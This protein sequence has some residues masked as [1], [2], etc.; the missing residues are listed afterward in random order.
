MR[1]GAPLA[2]FGLA[3]L[4]SGC[5][6]S[7]STTAGSSGSSSGSAIPTTTQTV[8]INDPSLNVTPAMSLTI[9]SGWK[10]D[11]AMLGSAC[12]PLPWPVFRAY[13][14]DGLTEMRNQPIF[15][16]TWSASNRPNPAAKAC[17]PLTGP[18]TA[19]EFL[20]YYVGTIPGGVHIVGP[21]PVSAKYQQGAQS[22]ANSMNANNAHLMAPLQANNTADTA[23]LRIETVNG[24]FVI[25][26][27]LRA[28]LECAIRS[29]A[30][31]FQGGACFVRLD[32]LRA[33]QGKLDA[34]ANLVDTNNLPNQ[35]P[36]QQWLSAYM[37]RQQ[38]QGARMLA[39]LAQLEQQESHMLL[40][41]HQQIM[42]TMQANHQA[43]MAQ[44]ESQF[45]SAMANA[46]ASMNAQ[47]TATSDWVDYALDQQTVA[48]PG[49]VAKVS[50]SY[51][52]TWSS[53][54]GGQTQ[55]FQTNDPNTN[56]NGVLSG[57]WTQ[58]TKVHGNGQPM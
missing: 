23:A 29:N 57:T 51:S 6:S 50:S 21:M 22:Y 33:P 48:G 4:L 28:T 31:P 49:G 15:G 5:K 37:Q 20:Q 58:D 44:Q 39:S 24:S 13:S 10:I 14:A 8:T 41:Q 52:Q 9:P 36:N 2:V 16:W 56:P 46:N 43:F 40:Q 47:S 53:T 55:W 11:G 42:A 12:N 17:L 34:L 38:Q 18:M 54:V 30:G 32:T 27:R 7:S 3:L 25:E 35:T 1:P 26:Q 19:A 45:H